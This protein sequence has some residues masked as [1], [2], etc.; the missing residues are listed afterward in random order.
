MR[1]FHACVLERIECGR[2]TLSAVCRVLTGHAALDH[3]RAPIA[4]LAV[5]DKASA[6]ETLGTLIGRGA[7]QAVRKG[8]RAEEARLVIIRYMVASV[9]LVAMVK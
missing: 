9:A 5:P 2:T 6:I 3:V 8:G 7:L 4:F 1:A